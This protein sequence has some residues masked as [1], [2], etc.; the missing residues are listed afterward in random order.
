[1]TPQHR[2]LTE[3]ALA[4]LP[5]EMFHPDMPP[6]PRHPDSVIMGGDHDSLYPDDAA[7]NYSRSTDD[8]GSASGDFSTG[9][10][11]GGTGT[12]SGGARGWDKATLAQ[13]LSQ[14]ALQSAFLEG[15]GA[16]TSTAHLHEGTGK[17]AGRFEE[18]DSFG[19]LPPQFR[20]PYQPGQPL[21]NVFEESESVLSGSNC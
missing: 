1:M 2:S 20:E 10:A 17:D 14:Q 9:A 15:S 16:G 13:H 7:S 6:S 12:A 3:A 4:T 8:A 5:S 18:E 19:A 21:E 11:G